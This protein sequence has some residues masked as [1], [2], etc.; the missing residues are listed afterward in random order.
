MAESGTTRMRT[1]VF[2]SPANH[3][4]DPRQSSPFSDKLY[5]HTSDISKKD[6]GKTNIESSDLENYFFI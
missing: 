1:P 2:N 5:V 4:W 3:A 6:S